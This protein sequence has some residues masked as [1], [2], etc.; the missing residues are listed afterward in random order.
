MPSNKGK[1]AVSKFLKLKSK[2]KAAWSKRESLK[3]EEADLRERLI[4][5]PLNFTHVSHMGPGDGLQ[6]LKD[7]PVVRAS[8]QICKFS[9]CRLSRLI[10]LLGFCL[11]LTYPFTIT[12]G[13]T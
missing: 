3:A 1:K 10:S 12:S 11:D 4:S 2:R 7:L 8:Q 5:M 9:W 13:Q 6:I